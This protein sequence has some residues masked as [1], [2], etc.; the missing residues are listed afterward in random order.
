M[1]AVGATAPRAAGMSRPS[2]GR[3]VI[4][5]KPSLSAFLRDGTLLDRLSASAFFSF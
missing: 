4:G 3:D 1:A 5:V 2:G